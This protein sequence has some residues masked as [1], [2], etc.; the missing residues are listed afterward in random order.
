MASENQYKSYMIID[1]LIFRGR[2]KIWLRKSSDIIENNGNFLGCGIK[3][4]I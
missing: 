4:D 2:F 1:F 3:T